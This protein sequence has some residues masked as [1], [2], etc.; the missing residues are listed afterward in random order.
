MSAHAF[1]PGP[2]CLGNGGEPHGAE[3]EVRAGEDAVL[4]ITGVQWASLEYEEGYLPPFA[5]AEANAHLIAAA[6]EL[7]EALELLS[8][9]ADATIKRLKLRDT[10]GLIEACSSALAK[11]RGDA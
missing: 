2:W 4:Y 9:F 8:V 5:Q 6:P 10:N 1:T 7:Y 3:F 11:A